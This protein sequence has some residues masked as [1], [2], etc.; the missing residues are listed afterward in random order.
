MDARTYLRLVGISTL[1]IGVGHW[2]DL[3]GVG[4]L[5]D[6]RIVFLSLI[7]NAIYPLVVQRRHMYAAMLLPTCGIHFSC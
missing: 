7:G 2:N 5:P 4:L 6:K 1:G 3:G